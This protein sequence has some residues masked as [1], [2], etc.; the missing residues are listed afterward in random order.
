MAALE[1]SGGGAG[2]KDQRPAEV[3]LRFIFREIVS[4]DNLPFLLSFSWVE[5]LGAGFCNA[6]T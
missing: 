4:L 1:A 5:K 3:R 2:K 6:I